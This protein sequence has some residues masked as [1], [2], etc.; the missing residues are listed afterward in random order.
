MSFSVNTNLGAMAA[1]QSLDQT[2]AALTETQNEISTGQK[3]SSAADNPAV[4]A[5]AQSMNST[6][7]GLAAVQDGLSFG[8]QVVNTASTA[9][10][11]ISSTL[12]TL[13]NT[14]T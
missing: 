14:L 13:Q 10:T 12:S 4:Y 8:G 5:I 6:I 9:V 1:L 3:V 11:N 7:A 2:N